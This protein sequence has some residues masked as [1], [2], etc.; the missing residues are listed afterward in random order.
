MV[1]NPYFALILILALSIPSFLGLTK[2]GFEDD[3]RAIFQSKDSTYTSVD[4]LFHDFGSDESDILLLVEGEELATK[5]GILRLRELV[6]ELNSNEQISSV[7]SIFDARSGKNFEPIF[8]DDDA[9]EVEFSNSWIKASEL[10]YIKGVLISEKAPATLVVISYNDPHRPLDELENLHNQLTA[11]IKSQFLGSSLK[12]GVTGFPIMRVEIIETLQ[13][14]QLVFSI[15]GIISG[16][17][18]T[19]LLFGSWVPVLIIALSVYSGVAWTLGFIGLAG[20][21]INVVNTV[22]PALILVIGIADGMHLLAGFRDGIL[23][24]LDENTATDQ[25]YLRVSK[26]CFV[27]SLTTGIAFASLIFTKTIIIQNFGIAAAMGA[28]LSLVSVL[29]IIPFL[30]RGPL[31]RTFA[32]S[33][34]QEEPRNENSKLL[35]ILSRS[36]SYPKIISLAGLLLTIGLL[37]LSFRLDTSYSHREN[38]PDTNPAF[39]AMSKL[40]QYFDGALPIRI[41][42]GW[43]EN[44]DPK[45]TELIKVLSRLHQLI[46]ADNRV[47]LPFSLLGWVKK[48]ASREE[49]NFTESIKK[50]PK[51]IKSRFIRADLR[52]TLVSVNLP[53]MAGSQKQSVLDNLEEGI[54]AIQA[55]F[56]NF[57]VELAG[58][59]VLS[60]R[61]SEQMIFEL[62]RSL[63][64][65]F[66][67]IFLTITIASKSI[68]LGLISIIP[69]VFPL[70]AVAGGMYLLGEPLRYSSVIVFCI[71]LGIAVDDTVH[72][73]MYYRSK[74]IAGASP[75]EAVRKSFIIVGRVL[76][77]TTIVLISGLSALFWSSLPTI[78][79][80]GILSC[81]AIALALLA[82]LFILPSLLLALDRNN[83]FK[84]NSSK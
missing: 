65:A 43:P 31:G 44:N 57:R 28:V 76:V 8:P 67:L 56:P 77:I 23:E 55:D 7:L 70:A 36:F 45:N 27:T 42:V 74:R 75:R 73:L 9:S 64:F 1:K 22:L 51:K 66:P 12:T 69:N 3:Y 39:Q 38:L 52:K 35:Q 25:S 68:F 40:D 53:D 13:R 11:D 19:F 47:G 33:V 41:L 15:V 72:F 71:C 60:S 82:D 37:V 30:L 46:E 14:D 32:K 83:S 6:L 61:R 58:I 18:V 24:G 54:K 62:A 78:R 21:N 50:I 4:E 26:A 49:F 84:N 34:R 10:P 63:A 80:F 5:K 81:T 48:G 59:K 29:L 2:L 20:E 79:L 17:L 16:T